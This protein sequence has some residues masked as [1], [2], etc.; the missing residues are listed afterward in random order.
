M[1][2]NE[3]EMATAAQV[4]PI[5]VRRFQP[6]DE[7]SFQRLNEEWIVRH[8]AIE[9]ADRELLSDPAKHILEPGGQILL[10]VADGDA[11]VGCCALIRKAPGVCQLAKMAVTETY[12]GQGI[13]RRLLD[14]AIE[15]AREMGA[16]QLSIESNTKL[17]TALHL[18]ESVGFRHLPPENT[19]PSPYSRTNVAME[20]F[21]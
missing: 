19:K 15:T 6:G 3:R 12:Q 17:S 10:A 11:V 9:D 20:M 2:D 14:A 8:F 4:S 13:G 5:L 16:A 21:L 18:Y 1:S 7:A